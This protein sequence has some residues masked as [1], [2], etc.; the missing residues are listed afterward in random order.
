MPMGSVKPR[1][2]PMTGGYIL[3]AVERH[4]DRG[5][6][7]RSLTAYLSTFL[8]LDEKRN[9]PNPPSNGVIYLHACNS[10][11]DDALS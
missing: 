9:T 2:E 4:G 3:V 11:G 1:E 5:L 7:Y 6:E 8:F 10:F